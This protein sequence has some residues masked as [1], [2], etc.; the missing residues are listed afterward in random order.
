M[1]V[2]R[3]L[4]MYKKFPSRLSLPPPEGPNSGILVIQDEKAEETCWFGL[5]KT[6]QVTNLPFPQNKNHVLQYSHDF[7]DAY[8]IP[9]LNQPLSSNRYYVIQQDGRRKGHAYANSKEDIRSCHGNT[10]IDDVKPKPLDPNN[11][12]Q[13]F[14]IHKLEGTFL[15]FQGNF[16]G[17][18]LT[19]DGIPPMLLKR[20]GWGVNTSTPH[21]FNLVDDAQ[22]LDTALRARLPEF[23]VPLS[24][25][26]S[27]P[28]IVGK[29]YSPFMFISEGTLL[30]KD[31]VSISM[32]YKVTLEQNWE[33]IFACENNENQGN[34]VFVDEFLPRKVILVAGREVVD[35]KVDNGVMWFKSYNNEGIAISAG[36]SLL[37]FERMKW[38]QERV[39]WVDEEN[40]KQL[41]VKLSIQ[42]H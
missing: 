5:F 9:V 22:G 2:T 31:Q 14:E 17:K 15:P 8:F 16:V 6:H 39:G 35:V 11:I 20:K 26:S 27:Q 1:Y 25:K 29:W 28:I 10:V 12:N 34:V 24:S 18:S 4:S 36:L 37:V 3:S 40:D 32:Y 38:E 7:F 33:Q 19:P 21:D 23:N 13:Q 42:P 30:L 41:G